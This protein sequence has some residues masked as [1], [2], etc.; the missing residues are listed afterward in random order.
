MERK[1]HSSK[2]ATL[3]VA[4]LSIAARRCEFA[5]IADLSESG[6]KDIL[7]LSALSAALRRTARDDWARDSILA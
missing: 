2:P 5:L 1:I 6:Q 7:I 3:R 4:E